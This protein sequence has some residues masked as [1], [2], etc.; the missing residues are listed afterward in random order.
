MTSRASAFRLPWFYRF[1]DWLGEVTGTVI[2]TPHPTA[3]GNRAEEIYYG[4]LKARRE[5]KK[6]LLL[7]SYDFRRLFGFR[8]TNVELLDVR[9]EYQAFRGSRVTPVIGNLVVTTY[10]LGARLIGAVLRRLTGRDLHTLNYFPSLGT[11]TLWQ[12]QPVMPD[13]SWE[14]VDRYDWKEQHQT[15]IPTTLSDTKRSLAKSQR[16]A[17]GL[18]EDAWFVCLHVRE[19]GFKG[20]W[21]A[22]RNAHI[23][24][25]IPA[26][27]D[28]TRRGGWVVRLGDSTMTRLPEM[29]RVIDY[30]FT[31]F[32]SQLM[33]IYLISEC[34]L[35]I[36]MMS[37]PYPIALLFNRPMITTNMPHWM[38][39]FPV[40][41]GDIGLFK[42]VYSER[43]KRYLSI[44]ECF[45][46][47]FEALQLSVL[48]PGYVL[49]ENEREELTAC[50]QEYFDRAE[51]WRPTALQQ[52]FDEVR[53]QE[54]KKLVST[55]FLSPD[56]FWDNRERYR[57]ASRLDSAVGVLSA[58]FLEANWEEAKL[59]RGAPTSPPPT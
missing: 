23:E 13:F 43:D 58:A 44:K 14:I 28:I 26:I 36:G 20:D 29:E 42:H 10:F 3:A 59:N 35:F 24:N 30:P 32:K 56:P 25:Y 8:Q 45:G 46:E 55:M 6:L 16:A 31:P 50:V 27:E 39:A 52:R 11:L 17:M 34:R 1:V 37:G 40:R 15:L 5:G 38:Q 2:L 48:G 4:L 54:G 47:P 9:T 53:L 22:W 21:L 19:G 49:Q 41:H 7:R 51:E 57:F 18:P 33:D 12:P